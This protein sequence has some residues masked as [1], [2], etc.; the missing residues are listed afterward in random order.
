[1]KKKI[2]IISFFIT[3]CMVGPD[4][5]RPH[6]NVPNQY[7]NKPQNIKEKLSL[8]EWWKNFNDNDLN[9]YINLAI[10]NNLNLKVAIEKIVEARAIYRIADA[11]LYPEIDLTAEAIRQVIS[12]NLSQ[13]SF[14]GT[15][16][17]FFQFG[18]DAT[19]ELDFFGKL[20][21]ERQSTYFSY[22][23]Q[24][25][26]ALDV[27]I[28]LL[29]D[30]AKAYVDILTLKNKIHI[31]ENK[32]YYQTRIYNLI[33][34]KFVSGL[35][36]EI[37]ELEIYN[38]IQI[39]NQTLT[40]LNTS[41]KTTINGLAVLLGRNP[42]NLS[43]NFAKL[44]QIPTITK[45]IQIGL[46]S[47]LLKRRPDVRSA[48]MVLYEKTSDIGVAIAD[49]F[50]QFSLVG[51]FNF[52]SQSVKTWF[53][54]ASKAWSI[55]PTMT[56]P[57]IDFGRRLANIDAKKSAQRQAIYTYK[58]SILLAFED[59]ENALVAYFNGKNNLQL[60]LNKLNSQKIITTL[61][62]DLFTSG[63]DSEIQYLQN[64]L[65]L[66]DFEND[67]IDQ[68]RNVSVDLIALI[69]ALGGSW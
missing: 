38:N 8:D 6:I 32:I 36:N 60:S 11:N 47:A 15:N 41:F 30:V 14:I 18:F 46:P 23:E 63:I 21:R 58:N 50:P 40:D 2:I 31:T 27:Y 57:L 56:M 53:R 68:K 22:L 67:Y 55:G 65:I 43:K 45:D 66:L 28:T 7:E 25:Y 16:Q 9:N 1:M 5:Q 24:K 35:A 61:S 42:E 4:P 69:K 62:K 26:N 51:T 13:S 19:W 54:W 17:N 59:V 37:S 39:L 3:S 10:A 34:D 64:E 20:R 33:K 48:E 49:L 12:K 29:S 44:K 52:E